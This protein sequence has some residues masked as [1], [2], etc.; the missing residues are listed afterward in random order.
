MRLL[1]ACLDYCARLR[2]I[3][4][5]SGIGPENPRAKYRCAADEAE[6]IGGFGYTTSVMTINASEALV[7][8]DSLRERLK[9]A[10]GRLGWL[11]SYL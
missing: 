8:L 9:E 5:L 11:R 1:V 2:T 7:H 3:E 4:P 6:A 10:S